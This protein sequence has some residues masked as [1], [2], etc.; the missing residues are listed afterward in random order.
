MS[1]RA[2]IQNEDMNNP[3]IVETEKFRYKFCS[4]F[5]HLKHLDLTQSPTE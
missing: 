5:S 2:Y 3:Y 4:T 1:I